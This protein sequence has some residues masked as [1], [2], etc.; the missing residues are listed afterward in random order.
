MAKGGSQNLVATNRQAYHRFAI[1][2]KWEAGIVLEGPEVRSIRE[3]RASI[4]ESFCRV[5]G[6]EAWIINMH[7]PQWP[8]SGKEMDPTR[9]RKL[10]L[11][12]SQLQQLITKGVR[13]GFT[14]IPL[15]LYFKRGVLKVEFAL[16]QGKQLYD[17][18]QDIK[19]RMHEREMSRAHVRQSK[20][21]R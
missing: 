12:R 16:C 10:L 7:I 11:H 21:N 8:H 20:G 13:K 1:L 5:V 6:K 9:M 17:K 2:E 18:R 19:K 4:K 14:L 15:R 3:G